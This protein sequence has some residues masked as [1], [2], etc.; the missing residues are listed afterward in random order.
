MKFTVLIILALFIVFRECPAGSLP[1][2]A[3]ERVRSLTIDGL[4]HAYNF[5][6]TTAN[7]RFD[8]AIALEPL[9]PRPY[10]SKAMIVFWRFVFSRNEADLDS[11]L[12]VADRVV[13]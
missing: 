2:T 12:A 3:I 11:F 13:A 8:E 9:Y 4:E 1:S 5:E 10:L 6:F 7:Q